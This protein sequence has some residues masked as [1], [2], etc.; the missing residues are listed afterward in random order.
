MDSTHGSNLPPGGKWKTAR[1]VD[2]ERLSKIRELKRSL[3]DLRAALMDELSN[4]REAR[5]AL[6]CQKKA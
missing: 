5:E 2:G 3:S 1:K 6:L 4:T